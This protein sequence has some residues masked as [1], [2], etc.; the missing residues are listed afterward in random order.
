M[1]MGTFDDVY[2]V[3]FICGLV[4][5]YFFFFMNIDIFDVK[6]CFR[7]SYHCLSG[8]ALL[9]IYTCYLCYEMSAYYSFS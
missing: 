9:I 5:N 1:G 3:N 4:L 8:I 7:Y 6:Y 2:H